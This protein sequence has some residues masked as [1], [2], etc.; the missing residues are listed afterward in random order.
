M[1]QRASW[2]RLHSAVSFPGADSWWGQGLRQCSLQSVGWVC[3]Y[4]LTFFYRDATDIGHAG[5]FP[6]P[7]TTKE[8]KRDLTHCFR[9]ISPHRGREGLAAIY[10]AL[11][12]CDIGSSHH[13]WPGSQARTGLVQA[14]SFNQNLSPP[15]NGFVAFPNFQLRTERTEDTACRDHSRSVPQPSVFPTALSDWEQWSP[16]GFKRKPQDYGWWP[17]GQPLTLPLWDY[18][19]WSLRWWWALWLCD[20]GLAGWGGEVTICL[21]VGG[22]TVH[23]GCLWA[24]I[25]MSEDQ[26]RVGRSASAMWEA[27]ISTGNHAEERKQALVKGLQVLNK[28]CAC[29]CQLLLREARLHQQLGLSAPTLGSAVLL[30]SS[31]RIATMYPFSCVSVCCAPLNCC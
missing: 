4:T 5:W 14:S 15:H 31:K 30:H 28:F 9:E 17:Q 18:V 25:L 19:P 24:G 8:T 11:G 27:F 26:S 23:I 22:R 16:R 13:C 12:V 21:E 3:L 6:A 29:F 2:G 7:V 20:G 10:L 1:I